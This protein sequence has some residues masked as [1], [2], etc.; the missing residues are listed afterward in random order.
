MNLPAPAARSER[1]TLALHA[2]RALTWFI[3]PALGSILGGRARTGKEERSRLKERYGR[4]SLPRPH[5][6]II[7]LHG[8]SVGESQMLVTLANALHEERPDLSFVMTTNTVTSARLL[9]KKPPA[10]AAHQYVPLDHP[11]FARR[12]I[13]HWSPS[14]VVFAES[15][16][17]PNLLHEAKA[18]GARLALINARMTAGSLENW[19]RLPKTAKTVLSLFDWISAADPET[20]AGLAALIER[21][22][23]SPGNLKSAASAPEAD[24]AALTELQRVYEG[25]KVWLAASTHIGEDEIVLDAHKNLMAEDSRWRVII[26]PRHP[27]RGAQIAALCHASGVS[28]AR[29]GAGDLPGEASVYIADTLG[30]MGLWY[31]LARPALIGGSLVPNI[32]GHNPLEPALLSTPMLSGPLT[33]NFASLFAEL[34]QESGVRIVNNSEELAR[35][36]AALAGPDGGSQADAARAVA[37]NGGDVLEAVLGDLRAL[38]PEPNHASA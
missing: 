34:E 12:F 31:R 1:L 25:C 2:Y 3:W 16:L 14:L 19:G 38:L 13:A 4:A 23:P 28:A 36:V 7:W 33:H 24:A 5:G 22:V 11:V 30:E 29:R 10:R 18:S 21:P 37:R 32:G 27:E 8:A 15:E 20:A 9:G 6:P 26:A 35:G 17:W